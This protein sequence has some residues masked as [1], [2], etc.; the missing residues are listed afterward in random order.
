MSS[1]YNRVT[2][3]LKASEI[4]RSEDIHLI[5]SSIQTAFQEVIRD[6]FGAGCILGGD[7]GDLKVIPTPDHIDQENMNY[8]EETDF[9]SFQ[10]RYLKQS[11]HIEKSEIQS[12]RVQ[13]IN[14][15]TYEPSVF[16]EIR[17]IDFNLIKETN[18]KL[19]SS[20]DPIDVVFTFNINHLPLGEYYF[21]IRPVDMSSSDGTITTDS[22]KVRYDRGGNYHEALDV[23]YDGL[24]YL[25]AIQLELIDTIEGTDIYST[26][27]GNNFDLFFEH[28]FSSGNTYLINPAPCIVL[29]E[30][31]YPIDTHVTIDG[32]SPQGDRIDLI[33]LNTNGELVVTQGLPYTGAKTEDKYP[34]NNTGLKIA[35]ITTFKN[36]SVQWV[37][38]SC[39]TINDGSM[40]SC[41]ICNSA[42]NSKIPLIE[43]DDDNNITRQRDVLERIRRLEKKLNYQIENNI[44]SRVKYICIVDPIMA[45]KAEEI[46]E[47]DSSGNIITDENGNAI[48]RIVYAE[49]SYGIS[50]STNENGETVLTMNQGVDSDSKSWSIIN[51]IKNVK[52]NTEKISATLRG[53]DVNIPVNKPSKVSADNDYYY[54]TV[55]STKRT[56]VTEGKKT[57]EVTKTS[58]VVTESS[59][60][61]E[62]KGIK[63]VPLTITIKNKKTGTVLHTIQ[64]E[65]NN[66]GVVH[67]DLWQYNLK[68]GTYKLTTSYGSTKIINTLKIFANNEFQ[69]ATKSEEKTIQIIGAQT[70]S[71]TSNVPSNVITG[72][73]SFY[74]D[75]VTVDT[76]NGEAYISKID[77]KESYVDENNI[78]D[79]AKKKMKY[80]NIQYQ[81]KS[82]NSSLQSEYPMINFIIQEDC[83]L[84]GITLNIEEF[85]NIAKYKIVLFQNE[86][87]FNLN[88]SRTSYVKETSVSRLKHSENTI[89]PNV[90][91]SDDWIT[92][93]GTSKGNDKITN[94]SKTISFDN[95]QLKKGTY[96]LLILGALKDKKKDGKIVIKEYRTA[97]ASTYGASCRVKGSSGTSGPSKVYIEGNSLVNRTWLFSLNKRVHQYANQGVLISKTIDMEK[98]ITACK[99]DANYDIPPGCSVETYVSNNG[100]K[101][102]VQT[103][104]FN[105]NITFSGTGS[106]L[107]WRIVFKGT[108]TQTPKLSFNEV[109]GYAIKITMSTAEKYIGYEDYGRCFSTPLLNANMITKSI[110]SNPNI[111]NAFE[112][113]EYCRLW[114]ED[115]EEAANIDIC[116]AYDYDNYQTDVGTK[117]KDWPTSIFFS[118]IFSNLKLSDFSQESVDYSNYTANIE[119]DENN[120]RFKL[121]SEYMAN[122]QTG[123]IITTPL[124]YLNLDQYDYSYGDITN[125]DIDMSHF[126]YTPMPTPVI[127]GNN[128]PEED[129]DGVETNTHKYNGSYLISG[130]YYQAKYS[131]TTDNFEENEENPEESNETATNTDTSIIWAADGGDPN[132]DEKACMIGISFDNGLEITEKYTTISLDVF[133]NLRDCK[134]TDEQGTLELDNEGK[135]QLKSGNND[136]SKYQNDDGFYYIPENTLEI[137][138]SLN[139]YGLIE[140]NDV[141]YGIAYPITTPLRSCHHEKIQLNLSELY[142]AT[143]YS[144]GVRVSTKSDQDGNLYASWH[145]GKHPS[146]HNGDIIGLGNITLSAY[147]M[148]PYLPYIYTGQTNRW[149][150]TALSD[151]KKSVALVQLRIQGKDENATTYNARAVQ[152]PIPKNMNP[153]TTYT[154]TGKIAYKKSGTTLAYKESSGNNINDEV[155]ITFTRKKNSNRIQTVINNQ[156]YV[157]TDSANEIVFDLKKSELG[158][159]FKVDTNIPL[160]PY[161]YIDVQ[162]HVEYV[163]GYSSNR[164]IYKGDIYIDLYDTTDITGATPIE[165]L[166]LPAW[167]KVQDRAETKQKKV[168]AWFKIHTNASKVKS[169]VLR[170]E[171][172]TGCVVIDLKLHLVDMLFYNADTMPALGPQMHVRVYPKRMNSLSNTKIR[173]FGCIYR[174]G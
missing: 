116:F 107:R 65:T 45:I 137:V 1:Y 66:K 141:T 95:I 123:E 76:D 148:R 117:Q 38:P 139:P 35:Y 62:Y 15:S 83:D 174:L 113:W 37:C 100:G 19:E 8:E 163:N 67:I 84:K 36:S 134:E 128:T 161:D 112:E 167:G 55:T 132:Y 86:K 109:K 129:E 29:G 149:N 99:V 133:V 54:V 151:A 171:N 63:E 56:L 146:L 130:P 78:N 5:Q 103:T 102:Y 111:Q 122:T 49:D 108:T 57:T 89:F 96:S 53:Y 52:V 154:T 20:E 41:T 3:S 12:I 150:W 24:N 26:D 60:T 104:S 4:A 121:Q 18:A 98:N 90:Y 164:E 93:K 44:P 50:S 25:P 169:F 136:S 110:L 85:N 124:F 157:N 97:D 144:V 70:I 126:D 11:I 69:A 135:P 106:E 158:K 160:A 51:K 80:G 114:M 32:P 34:I 64:T 166:P 71:S 138:F 7:E 73:D 31:V 131:V 105:K 48:K 79:A 77:N 92:V 59:N 6:M 140:D 68:A 30:K 33:S 94:V 42:S 101:T 91:Y 28:K 88:S 125:E 75:K 74:T 21:I 159:L 165:S 39:G 10:D 23:S 147:N 162:Y 127:Y 120:F 152:M 153:A 173:K 9:I 87:I 2:G 143:V 14:T 13:M 16:A 82:T 46:V 58:D 40:E 155:D 118:Q 115:E 81:I 47:K 43:Q 119:P 72:N 22:F 168:H 145:E 27:I 142:G 61:Y 172:P 17:D 156:K 170:R